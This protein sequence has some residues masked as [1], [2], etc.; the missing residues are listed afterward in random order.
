MESTNE[1]AFRSK[2]KFL[3]AA[4]ILAVVASCIAVSMPADADSE[5]KVLYIHGTLDASI[6]GS[7]FQVIEVNGD[8][9]I[10]NGQFVIANDSFI[11]DKDVTLTLKSG[12]N[13][14]IASGT[15]DIRG[16]VVCAEGTE[17]APTF[18]V[19][20]GASVS[21]SGN[22]SV[23]GPY[24][25]VCE[26]GASAAVS[27]NFT[28]AEKGSAVISGF[29]VKKGGV[30][31]IES[32]KAATH[33]Q[34]IKA[35]SESTVSISG[36]TTYDS[37]VIDSGSS[38][39][40]AEDGS[41]TQIG[42][43]AESMPAT[44][45]VNN[46]TMT[47]NGEFS[48]A[49]T[50]SGKIVADS[51]KSCLYVVTANSGSTFEAK[52]LKGTAVFNN[53]GATQFVVA[54]VNGIVVTGA[55]T[56]VILSGTPVAASSEAAMDVVGVLLISE[57]MT[58]PKEVN[59][60]LRE[61]SVLNVSS[62]VTM[63]DNTKSAP[64]T[65]TGTLT[66]TG[67]VK[68]AVPLVL[69]SNV[70][71]TPGIILNGVYYM[72]GGYHYY[73]T[74]ANALEAQPDYL[75]L[76]GDIVFDKDTVIPSTMTV[77]MTEAN[78]IRIINDATV[79]VEAGA[80]FDNGNVPINVEDGTLI[81]MD[82]DSSQT[83][84]DLVISDVLVSSGVVAKFTNLKKAL[85]ESHSGDVIELRKDHVYISEDTVIPEE[86]TLM[87]NGKI[88]EL[89]N[90]AKLT[91]NGTL[92]AH[93]GTY[94]ITNGT[95]IVNG[96]FKFDVPFS[97]YS[98][99]IA[100]AYY[101]LDGVNTISPLSYIAGNESRISDTV[102]MYGDNVVGNVSLNGTGKTIYVKSGAF[103]AESLALKG[104]VFDAT[105]ASSV[106]GRIAIGNGSIAFVNAKGFILNP[107]PEGGISLDGAPV[108]SAAG[109]SATFSGKSRIN[110]Q[111]PE[112][113]EIAF[114]S[115]ADT[116]I[117]N[118]FTF[119]SDV[120][121]PEGAKVTAEQSIAGKAIAIAGTLA[122]SQIA[123]D[124]VN[125]NA[126]GLLTSGNAAMN[127]NAKSLRVDGT[128]SGGNGTNIALKALSGS[129][130]IVLGDSSRIIV[131]GDV[132]SIDSIKAGNGFVLTANNIN[133][134][135]AEISDGMTL[136]A[137]QNFVS[138]GR[139]AAGN[140]AAIKAKDVSIADAEFGDS[141]SITAESAKLSNTVLGKNSVISVANDLSIL[142]YSTFSQG[143]KVS[144]KNVSVEGSLAIDSN[145]ET[146]INGNLTV[147]GSLSVILPA[148]VGGSFS[149]AGN[150][151]VAGSMDL[152]QIAAQ[153]FSG[154]F[155]VSGSA[156]IGAAD[157]SAA[158]SGA[159]S[160]ANGGSLSIVDDANVAFAKTLTS[161][162]AVNV[163]EGTDVT[164][165]GALSVPGSFSTGLGSTVTAP[166]LSVP[167]TF[168][169]SG[170]T[171]IGSPEIGG[172][173]TVD[174]TIDAKDGNFVMYQTVHIY[175]SIPTENGVFKASKIYA[176]VNESIFGT[177]AAP[178]TKTP[179]L[180]SGVT[181]FPD[182]VAYVAPGAA[183]SGAF[184]GF[185]STKFFKDDDLYLT[186][187]A[188]KDAYVDYTTSG[189]K[190]VRRTIDSIE[191]KADNA[192]VNGWRATKNVKNADEVANARV[193][194]P[195]GT[196]DS[197]WLN[198]TTAIYNFKLYVADETA[199]PMVG[200]LVGGQFVPL[201]LAKTGLNCYESPVD[202]E[203]GDYRVKLTYALGHEEEYIDNPMVV[204]GVLQ[205]DYDFSFSGNPD[206]DRRVT[207]LIQFSY[208]EAEAP[209]ISEP[210]SLS[211]TDILLIIIVIL[212]IIVAIV[213]VWRVRRS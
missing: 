148:S 60:D 132:T 181:I 172:T 208:E 139:I 207:S 82:K 189:G 122:A 11:V 59:M 17:G 206:N 70:H 185:D 84:L 77:D 68:T 85:E 2:E 5:D 75:K 149:V 4:V 164:I 86:V 99:A 155:S 159:A 131:D 44:S 146:V 78:S 177:G 140:S 190:E 7:S 10:E 110:V 1:K 76:Y 65:G 128:L 152:G 198:Y 204:N 165:A 142:G 150:T 26:D 47:V 211:I 34:S 8:L 121:I 91:V 88:L 48:G 134:G 158:V 212:I 166:A 111:T 43:N 57:D 178:A 126:G 114:A 41:L 20:N 199:T 170:D 46:G 210:H 144:A 97:T 191:A 54:N 141:A 157:N 119:Y 201:T 14:T 153:T 64:I 130:R 169:N 156:T 74:L 61:G 25:F 89:I 49:V 173:S 127:L 98:S 123:A 38:F 188:D 115:D 35:E 93:P 30:V 58:F 23:D 162:G 101:T 205:P 3:A 13:V 12:S 18:L 129:G 95:T 33:I 9:T 118:A 171:T 67:T 143:T 184:S 104:F 174:G 19:K 200:K 136:E 151:D 100:G 81:L 29:T 203:A 107:S 15:A 40:I 80:V 196:Y 83:K 193:Y 71:G 45:I 6:I 202:L 175:G 197:V 154:D 133:L 36:L 37:M 96:C 186:V 28:V 69:K 63:I 161:A 187:F 194:D 106:D 180:G 168:V 21:I 90:G 117:T 182:G 92:D 183:A 56:G 55:S 125:I 192:Y 145:T 147:P 116:Y 176:G 137:K 179:S 163:G 79:T 31:A 112:G 167:G 73:T 135:S 94:L 113:F 124:S 103:T 27:G 209:I 160:V 213:V 50:N 72:K 24:G 66:V 120:T 109:A 138:T 51:A 108:A 195:Y 87:V 16:N 42:V 62:Y 22:V 39:V 52:N 105:Q 32:N 102:E 53:R